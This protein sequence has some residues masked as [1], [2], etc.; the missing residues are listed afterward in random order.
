MKLIDLLLLI[1]EYSRIKVFS[2][3]EDEELCYYDGKNSIDE[4]Y[5][6]CEVAFIRH[7]EEFIEIYIED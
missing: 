3:Y 5:N 2:Y 1:S 7:N 4:K 6:D